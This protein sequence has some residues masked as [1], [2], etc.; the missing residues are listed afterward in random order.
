[1]HPQSISHGLKRRE[2]HALDASFQAV[3]MG[4]VQAGAVGKFLLAPTLL[5]LNLAKGEISAK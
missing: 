5:G 3:K 1:L 2:R 4:A